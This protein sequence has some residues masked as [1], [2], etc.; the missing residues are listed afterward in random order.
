MTE[1]VRVGTRRSR[2]ALVQ[3]ESVLV[4]LA[5][6]FPAIRFETVPIETSGDRDPRPG[7]SPDFTDAI[8]R[9]L[10]RGEIDLAVHSAKDLDSRLASGLELDACGRRADPRD[11]RIEQPTPSGTITPAA[12]RLGY[13]RDPRE[14]RHSDRPRPKRKGRRRDPGGR[15]SDTP[16]AYPGDRPNTVYKKLPSRPRSGSAGGGDPRERPFGSTNR[17]NTRPRPDSSG[18]RCRTGV[19]RRPGW[20]LSGSTRGAR[21]GTRAVALARGGG[22]IVGRDP[23]Y[24]RQ[25]SGSQ[26]ARGRVGPLPGKV[27]SRGGWCRDPGVAT[28]GQL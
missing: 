4:R 16:R 24:P 12:R 27:C 23:P 8:D 3:T 7:G 10:T 6:R 1:R 17:R 22:A 18:G 2:L 13:R 9:A 11:C 14:C 5:G 15:G 25:P 19:L 20:R 21:V 28:V 26:P